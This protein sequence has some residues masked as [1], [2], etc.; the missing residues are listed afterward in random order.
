[1]LAGSTL[2]AHINAPA[3]TCSYIC[4]EPHRVLTTNPRDEHCCPMG[5]HCD[6]CGLC[7]TRHY[8]T[9]RRRASGRT[10]I[11]TVLRTHWPDRTLRSVRRAQHR[12]FHNVHLRP[13][14]IVLVFAGKLD[15][16]ALLQHLRHQPI[17]RT[18]NPGA[19]QIAR[20][21]SYSR[22]Q[23][24]LVTWQISCPACSFTSPTP[25]VGF[26]SI[27]FTGTPGTKCT[28]SPRSCAGLCAWQ[29]VLGAGQYSYT[30]I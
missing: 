2:H 18:L 25:S 9:L 29:V 16:R 10:A 7:S 8:L 4:W 26:A 1:M 28:C 23:L 6:W 12:T 30:L 13:L 27:G 17:F 19:S 5:Y 22:R 21:N 14:P 3:T 20:R 11:P 15:P 24:R